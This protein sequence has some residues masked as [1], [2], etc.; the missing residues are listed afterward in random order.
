MYRFLWLFKLNTCKQISYALPENVTC[1]N[2]FRVA[3]VNENTNFN[4]KFAVL[5]FGKA[6]DDYDWWNK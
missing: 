1:E 2:S 4:D 3:L 6:P 5:D